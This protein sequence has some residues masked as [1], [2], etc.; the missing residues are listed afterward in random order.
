MN[1]AALYAGESLDRS[2]ARELFT[3]MVEGSLDDVSLAAALIALKLNG[4]T[5]EVIAG[6]AEAL[7][8]A[9]VPFPDPPRDAV[10]V[11]GTGG[12]GVSTV[13]V[14]TLVALVGA[15][16][17]LPQVKHG[18]RAVSSNC[19][20]A[21]VLEHFGVRLDPAPST[22][23]RA[24]TNTDFCYLH[25]PAYHPGVAHAMPVRR[26]LGVRTVMNLLGPLV[27]PARPKRQLTGVYDERWCEPM[28]R[29]LD[30]LGAE[31]V[32]VVHGSGMDELALHGPTTVVACEH[33]RLR[34]FSL[35]PQDAGLPTCSLDRLEITTREERLQH[36]E[37]LLDGRGNDADETL[38]AFNAAAMFFMT[39][40]SEDL[41]SGARLALEILRSGALRN[42][43]QRIAE[44]SHE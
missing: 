3:A 39:K 8:A 33:G 12:D 25:A 32:W 6:A 35:T 15:E 36:F 44:A 41:Q 17:G 28:A 5:S 31:C 38:V 30:A 10:D 9:A 16:A 22:A 26:I 40:H 20:S 1:C 2:G 37:A 7:L 29:T 34:R 24:L 43:L 11:C 23:R 21:D 13:N 4:E 19:G 42:R 14:S 27:N 18:N